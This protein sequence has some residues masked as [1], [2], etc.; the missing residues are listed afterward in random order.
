MS[1]QTST[2]YPAS[3][4][5][6]APLR[7]PNHPLPFVPPPYPFYVSHMDPISNHPW[8][9]DL[10]LSCLHVLIMLINCKRYPLVAL[11][12]AGLCHKPL[13]IFFHIKKHIAARTCTLLVKQGNMAALLANQ[14]RV[15]DHRLCPHL[16]LVFLS[17]PQPS[18]DRNS[19]SQDQGR[20]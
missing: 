4:S 20:I 14:R 2:Y 11:S 13:D 8:E 7:F 12:I 9:L 16:L 3:C 15:V 10:Q 17:P 19:W 5:P 6:Q 1:R 18:D